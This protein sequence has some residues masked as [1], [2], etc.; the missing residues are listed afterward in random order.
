MAAATC[1]HKALSQVKRYHS[2][3]PQTAVSSPAV[4]ASLEFLTWMLPSS[5]RLPSEN[6]GAR[7]RSPRP[8]Y[9][10]WHL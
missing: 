9:Q 10:D 7:S 5:Y 4:S 6:L 3:P 8:E 2:P 1:A